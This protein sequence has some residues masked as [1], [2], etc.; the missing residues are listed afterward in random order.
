MG[1]LIC[2]NHFKDEDL[3]KSKSNETVQLA[4]GAI[5]FVDSIETGEMSEQFET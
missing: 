5:P 3:I 1:G 2:I 4:V